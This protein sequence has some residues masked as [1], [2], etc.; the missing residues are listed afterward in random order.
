MSGTDE[1]WRDVVGYE[2]I[3]RIS[4]RGNVISLDREIIKSNGAIMKV[5]GGNKSLITEKDGY[6]VFRATKDRKGRLL[7]VHREMLK[8]FRPI[9][10]SESMVVNHISGIKDENTLENCEWATH[11]RNSMHY[12][13]ELSAGRYNRSKKFRDVDI[14]NA[15][16]MFLDRESVENI[17]KK[18]GMEKYTLS[19]IVKLKSHKYIVLDNFNEKDISKEL[20]R[21]YEERKTKTIK[22]MNDF[23]VSNEEIIT[24][25]YDF[26][27]N[28][29]FMGF[30]FGVPET[31]ARFAYSEVE[32]LHPEKKEKRKVRI[33]VRKRTGRKIA[34]YCVDHN[35]SREKFDS[36]SR[37]EYPLNLIKKEVFCE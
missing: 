36:E 8:A 3:Y 27:M 2:G 23:F 15:V 31:Y 10:N 28:R 6:K 4:S 26:G 24:M 25:Y 32:R 17:I 7:K 19:S 34:K 18:M 11:K 21:R 14:I 13:N 16:Q 5:K 9:V 20:S 1:L 22:S 33:M 30:G 35:I 12:R 29:E 37:K